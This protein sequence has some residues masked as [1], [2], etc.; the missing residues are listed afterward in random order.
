MTVPPSQT[1]FSR[2]L[3]FPSLRSWTATDD[4]STTPGLDE[5]S[6]TIEVQSGFGRLDLA[7]ADPNEVEDSI[8]RNGRLTY[9]ATSVDTGLPDRQGGLTKR[10]LDELARSVKDDLSIG[11]R[12]RQSSS[13]NAPFASSTAPCPSSSAMSVSAD[14]SP[15]P[16]ASSPRRKTL[17]VRDEPPNCCGVPDCRT[18]GALCPQCSRAVRDRSDD[19]LFCT[20]Q[21][22][23]TSQWV[24]LQWKEVFGERNKRLILRLDD[25]TALDADFGVQLDRV[26]LLRTAY[27]ANGA[28]IYLRHGDEQVR[29]YAVRLSSDAHPLFRSPQNRQPLRTAYEASSAKLP[30]HFSWID[31]VLV[32]GAVQLRVALYL[33]QQLASDLVMRVV[34][35]H[36]VYSDPLLGPT[37]Q[38]L[39]DG[40]GQPLFANVQTR[41]LL[42]VFRKSSQ[43][44]AF[45]LDCLRQDTGDVILGGFRPRSQLRPQLQG[46]VCRGRVLRL[47]RATKPPVWRSTVPLEEVCLK[48]ARLARAVEPQQIRALA[49]DLRLF[50]QLVTHPQHSEDL[51]GD[52]QVMQFFAQQR[53]PGFL[54]SHCVCFDDLHL[55]SATRFLPLGTLYDAFRRRRAAFSLRDTQRVMRFL[56]RQAQRMH[57][58]GLSH[59]DLFPD[60]VLLRQAHAADETADETADEADDGSELQRVELLLFDFGQSRETCPRPSAA[61]PLGAS[62]IPRPQGKLTCYTP[63]AVAA[64]LLPPGHPLAPLVAAVDTLPLVGAREALERADAWQLGVCLFMLLTGREPVAA[65]SPRRQ[66]ELLDWLKL[67]ASPDALRAHTAE[68]RRRSAAALRGRDAVSE[69][70]WALLARLLHRDPRRRGDTEQLAAHDFVSTPLD[71][72]HFAGPVGV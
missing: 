50:R 22:W 46:E 9:R 51:V 61:T 68:L 13:G 28:K 8:H 16:I 63:E 10:K 40:L 33:E 60:N 31:E 71:R 29:M 55:F 6:S 43:Q 38:K 30:D 27:D 24:Q 62:K 17:R 70:A 53:A 34:C 14:S 56:L 25:H 15:L 20:D 52:V 2:D 37:G 35:D 36:P 47:D 69:E 41:Q 66:D 49:S 58:A 21:V 7:E 48:V 19:V 1:T 3:S 5:S 57:A 42:G 54:R 45:L 65:H 26:P 64:H 44:L 12:S 72:Q 32:I 59:G 4:Q 18:L 11:S 39:L 23:V 67:A